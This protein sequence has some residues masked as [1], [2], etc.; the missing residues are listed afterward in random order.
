MDNKCAPGKDYKEGSCFTFDDLKEL[1]EAYNNAHTDKISI[2]NYKTKK[3][4]LKELINRFKQ[5][6]KCDD[7]VCWL[8]T[9]VGK[10]IKAEIHENT[11]RP[12]GPEDKYGWLSTEEIDNV[13]K[14]Y[15]QL[16]PDF[17]FLGAVPS[18]FDKLPIYETT[19]LQFKELEKTT[20]KIGLVINLDTH[21]MSGSH[22]VA[23][24]ANLKT[25]TIYYFD[26]FRKPPQD[27]VRTFVTRLLSYMATKSQTQKLNIKQ[28]MEDYDVSDEFDVRYNKIQHQFK[29]SECGVYSIHFLVKLL[30]GES[31]D[32]IV[33]NVIDDATM[34]KYRQTIFRNVN[35]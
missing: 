1:A 6:Y 13:M 14:Q 23:L 15:E 10:K 17:K 11:F 4:L 25:N 29:N 28:F 26:S 30:E 8:G 24:Y 20:P 12:T 7:Q 22:W 32:K 33:N 21:D 16:Y 2:D 3:A 18:D 27:R 19:D 35:K 9:S 5:Q 34:N 31:F